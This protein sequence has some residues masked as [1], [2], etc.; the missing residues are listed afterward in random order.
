MKLSKSSLR[1]IVFVVAMVLIIQPI[2]YPAIINA[3]N[4]GERINLESIS[5][6]STH[7]GLI[8][9][10][11]YL[12]DNEILL[13]RYE[14][15]THSN[16]VFF[17]VPVLLPQYLIAAHTGEIDVTVKG[18]NGY[19]DVG[20]IFVDG[21][22]NIRF[23]LNFSDNHDWSAS[24]PELPDFLGVSTL[25]EVLYPPYYL[26]YGE[27]DEETTSVTDEEEDKLDKSPIPD[28]NGGENEQQPY[29]LDENAPGLEREEEYEEEY[30]TEENPQLTEG[31]ETQEEA[32]ETEFLD[33]T[34][35]TGTF[36]LPL[37]F[38]APM[39]TSV[40]DI[41]ENSPNIFTH[42]PFMAFPEFDMPTSYIISFEIPATFCLDTIP[43]VNGV[44]YVSFVIDGQVITINLLPVAEHMPMIARALSASLNWEDI[45]PNFPTGSVRRFGTLVFG[46]LTVEGVIPGRWGF[47]SEGG[48]AVGGNFTL[49]GNARADFGGVHHNV[50]LQIPPE[51]RLV[52]GGNFSQT[53]STF[54]ANL[55]GVALRSGGDMLASES[56]VF[57]GVRFIEQSDGNR[58]GPNPNWDSVPTIP[59]EDMKNFFNTAHD[60]LTSLSDFFASGELLAQERVTRIPA[61][62][63]AWQRRIIPP[64]YAANYTIVVDLNLDLQSNQHIFAG[65]D[66]PSWFRGNYIVNVRGG[67][68]P[69]HFGPEGTTFFYTPTHLDAY[70]H[71]RPVAYSHRIIWNIPEERDV[72][73]ANNVGH[74]APTVVGTLLAPRATFYAPLGGN[75]KGEVI[76][77]NMI[78]SG[79][80]WEQHT[81]S[82][83]Q[84]GESPLTPW[85]IEPRQPPRP[86]IIE[87]DEEESS[88]RRR[89]TP[90]PR[91]S[92]IPD[93][94][95]LEEPLEEELLEE[96]LLEEELPDEELPEE[97]L[98]EEELP[99]SELPNVRLPDHE[100]DPENTPTTGLTPGETTPSDADEQE[101]TPLFT[102]FGP[103]ANNQEGIDD[104]DSVGGN[105]DDTETEL[106]T[107]LAD[108]VDENEFIDIDMAGIPLAAESAEEGSPLEESV[109]EDY[110][111]LDLDPI[112]LAPLD[113]ISN[114]F[115]NPQTGDVDALR[116]IPIAASGAG[117]AGCAIAICWLRLA[118]K[119]K[120]SL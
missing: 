27:E 12:A 77:A 71:N 118:K 110:F 97:E 84:Q 2:A 50:G 116:V 112:P 94:L 75:V 104:D 16:E 11:M 35:E 95:P 36:G 47:H 54:D 98:P 49:T 99:N 106:V 86:P 114:Y 93:E 15:V 79:N 81:T 44:R 105:A 45:S 9:D 43:E 88:E 23:N 33:T 65:F 3:F 107:G 83:S 78:H 60:Q 17:D 117:A 85:P 10:G 7:N 89:P 39:S 119:G 6:I 34:E 111:M 31:G 4:Q 102:P 63:N 91:P 101:E 66:F 109:P 25:P 24:Y 32:S 28:E 67:S 62:V 96:E 46:D 72:I 115:R 30:E 120:E 92:P 48:V 103:G 57:N 70:N 80:G 64:L 1:A 56:S 41:Y 76:V 100:L 108:I 53:D 37:Y 8:Y 69:L 21:F 90:R 55:F 40:F 38:S 26:E 87:E 61:P 18:E 51:V 22:G 19:L 59:D 113:R 13:V 20:N 42:D 52:L 14:F 58:H 68:G 29:D 74:A 5:A 73:F 82:L